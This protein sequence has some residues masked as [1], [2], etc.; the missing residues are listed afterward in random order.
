MLPS[1]LTEEIAKGLKSFVTTGFETDTPFFAGMFHRFA[2]QPGNLMKG[3]YLSVGLPFEAGKTGHCRFFSGFETQYPPYFHQ[4]QAWARLRSSDHPRS[5]LIATGTGSGKTECFLYPLLDDCLQQHN[6]GNSRGIKAIVIYPMNALATDQASR[7]ARLIH[8]V[9]E[10]RGKLR[11]GLF[12]GER[13]ER[14]SRTMGPDRV[15]TDKHALRDDPPDILLTNY[16]ML[17]FLLL[18]PGDRRLWRHNRPETLRYLVVDEL[19]TFDGAQGTDLACLIRRLKARLASPKGHLI[20]VGTSATLGS[21]EEQSALREYAGRIFQSPFDAESVITERRQSVDSFLAGAQIKYVLTP[22]ATMAEL[23]DPDRYQT[24]NDYLAAQYALLF[25]G[26]PEAAPDD[27]QWR[28][29]LGGQLKQ[30][31]LFYNLLRALDSEPTSLDEVAQRLHLS[32]PGGAHG[33]EIPLINSLC[34]LISTARNANNQP[35]VNL[36]MQ[37]WVRELRRMVTPLRRPTDDEGRRLPIALGFADDQQQIEGHLSL[38]L[39]QCSHCHATAW[40]TRLAI[41][42]STIQSEL[43]SIYQAFF[44]N[45]QESTVL[46]PLLED[47]APPEWKGIEHLL[48]AYCGHLQQPADRG[49]CLAC[50]ETELHRVFIPY[51]KRQTKDGWVTDHHCPVCASRNTLMV[52]GSRVASL[53]SVAIHHS[54]ASAYNHD[55]KLITFSDGVQDAAHRAGFFESRT[56]QHNMRMAIAQAI[57]SA[58][59]A[60]PR[61][62]QDLPRFWREKE[63][64]PEALDEIPFIC[65]FLAPN[66]AWLPAFVSLV[67]QGVLPEDHR[68][69]EQIARRME[70]EVLAEFGYRCRIGRSLERTRTAA[71]GVR[72][73]PVAQAASQLLTPLREQFGLRHLSPSGV[74]HFLLGLLLRMKQR[75]AIAH[76]FLDGYVASGGRSFLLNRL[77]WMPSFSEKSAVPLFLCAGSH[78][79]FDSLIQRNGKGWYQSWFYR[80]LASEGL[81]PDQIERMVYPLI[82]KQLVQHGLIR[83]MESQGMAV[84]GINPEH[85]YLSREVAVLETRH[86]CDRLVV[87]Q[88]MAESLQGMPAMAMHDHDHYQQVEMKPHWLAK[89]YQR[90]KIHRVI[91]REHTGLLG[92]KRREQV[93]Q[94]FKSGKAPWYPNL[95]SATPTL[96]MGIDIGNLSSVLLCSTPP[97]QANYLQRIGR[98]GRRDGNAFNLTLAAGAPHDLYFYADPLQMMA[99]RVA[100]PG[101]FLN[102]SAVIKRQ[103]TAYCLD[104]WVASG[105]DDRA[106]PLRLKPVLDHVEQGKMGGFPYNFLQFTSDHAPS[107]LEGFLMLFEGELSERSRRYLTRFLLDE[108]DAAHEDDASHEHS[109]RIHLIK[110]LYV[111]VQERAG[112]KRR[113]GELGR[114]LKRLENAPQDEAT[115]SQIREISLER[116]G[117]QAIMREIN[118][119]QTM[120]FLADEGLLPNYAFPEAGVILRSVIFRK[121]EKVAEEGGGAYLHDVYEYERAAAMAIGE[122]APDNSFYAGGH[123][124]TIQQ[125]DLN[126]SDIEVWRLCPSCQHAERERGGEPKEAC[127]GCGNAMW[128]DSGQLVRMLRLRRVMAN[129]S[130]RASRIGDDNENREPTFYTRQMLTNFD[131]SSVEAAWRI[132][133]DRLPFG[134][135]FIRKATFREINFGELGGASAPVSIAG[136]EASRPGFR[137]CRHCGMVQNRRSKEQTHAYA[138]KAREKSDANNL[139]DFLYL[140]REFSSEALRILLPVSAVGED[141]RSL[142]SFIAALQLGLKRKFGGKVDHLRV[143]DYTEPA[144]DGGAESD[145]LRRHYLMLYDSVPG[146]TG[147]LQEL[148]HSPE[149]LLELFRLARDTMATCS[150]NRDRDRDGCYSCLYAFRNSHGMENTSRTTAVALLSRILDLADQFEPVSSIDRIAVNPLL[151]SALEARFIEAIKRISANGSEPVAVNHHASMGRR[152]TR[153]YHGRRSCDSGSHGME[154]IGDLQIWQDIIHGKPGYYLR[155]DT[156]LYTIEPQ[157]GLGPADGVVIE[158]RPDFL[159]RSARSGDGFRPIALFMDGYR[160]HQQRV[161]DDS[162]KRLALVQS[163]RFWQWSLTWDDV[164]R[165]LHGATRSRNPFTEHLNGSMDML[166]HKL[167]KRWGTEE[168]EP[169]ATFSP[170]RQLLLFL[171]RPDIVKWQCYLFTRVLNWF[172]QEQ[173]M[174]AEEIKEALEGSLPTRGKQALQDC[175]KTAFGGAGKTDCDDPLSIRCA[176]PL[177]AISNMEPDRVIASIQL[178]SAAVSE[179]GFKP[180]WQGFLQ[181][182]NLMQFLPWAV[183]A[184]TD[185]I[186]SGC[187]EAIPWRCVDPSMQPVDDSASPD[188]AGVLDDV[189]EEFRDGLGRLLDAGIAPP[190]IAFELLD[191]DEAIVAEAEMAWVAQKVAGLLPEQYD[192]GADHFAR[193]GWRT[194]LLDNEGRWVNQMMEVANATS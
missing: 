158:S 97:T 181:A 123:K 44:T 76:H 188:T 139:I 94:E 53:A 147:Y 130:D 178:D 23:L 154:A 117:L 17:D 187:Y 6:E 16:K 118:G 46:L 59:V 150:C 69:D 35:F 148:M 47:E 11:V 119:K 25:T 22:T 41:Q 102:A 194:V 70:W 186:R 33:L 21:G 66:M 133:S 170:L 191:D 111:L 138:C 96:E 136:K 84:W 149:Q 173:M 91:A 13:E 31:Q 167:A 105:I 168:F 34:A 67:E 141:S 72:L 37:L 32:L 109:M 63:R 157:V 42:Q 19:H 89:L 166:R 180:A 40:L 26:E 4:E 152:T 77:P 189:L 146:G 183:C 159:I 92:R 128:S 151:D 83:E 90:G 162:M 131:R 71:M 10:L 12:V 114:L 182:Y 106:L 193:H 62:C 143:M 20:A 142:H 24:V 177:E 85:L 172:D 164:A 101:V 192:T 75:G 51:L 116:S 160:Y 1:I 74:I 68:L 107:L 30:H 124:V 176:I 98:A 45:N 125:V 190:L 52:F 126:L 28:G 156:R 79:Q 140:Y 120:N 99:G 171:S 134:F 5:T 50:G 29:K 48:C 93:E 108:P 103:L 137:L 43:R 121:K 56:W 112:L 153:K 86:R 122:L 61:F 169:I 127:P 95:L 39:V 104:R 2:E 165:P 38:P 185:G 18:R 174:C 145:D 36:R 100:P 49:R 113:I 163:G 58:G 78:P 8:R 80:A 64:N 88:A 54:F 144:S 73:E 161:T 7:F 110:Q 155:I 132:K 129:A 87:P 14:P 15:I 115:R 3:P 82:M 135:E 65:R 60:L 179:K 57:P 175:G 27:E 55:R 184:T 9:P 81:V